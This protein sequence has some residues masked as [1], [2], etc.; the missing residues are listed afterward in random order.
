MK[1]FIMA[2]FVLGFSLTPGAR[3]GNGKANIRMSDAVNQSEEL[4]EDVRSNTLLQSQGVS[5]KMGSAN[6]NPAKSL[7]PAGTQRTATVEGS[8]QVFRQGEGDPKNLQP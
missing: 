3:A 2:I 5:V 7:S 8:I 1:T 6:L 4:A